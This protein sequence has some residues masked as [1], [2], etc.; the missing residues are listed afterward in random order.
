MAEHIDPETGEVIDA[1]LGLVPL[2]LSAL[3]EDELAAALATPQQAYAALQ[4]ARSLNARVPAGLDK[5]RRALRAAE[6]DLSLAKAVELKRLREEWSKATLTELR[7]LAT[8][9]DAVQEALDA[10]DTAWLLFEYAQDWAKAIAADID[11]L[12]SINANVRAEH[13]S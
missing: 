12:R 8:V 6:R 2:N 11:L 13:K 4:K 9:S 10:R 1:P 5:Y 3:S 7:E